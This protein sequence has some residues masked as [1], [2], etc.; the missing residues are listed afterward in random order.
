MFKR[1]DNRVSALCVLGLATVVHVGGC[2]DNDGGITTGSGGVTSSGGAT[3]TGG[4]GG[5][6]SGGGDSGGA[7]TS[8]GQTAD[9]GTGQ[10]GASAGDT[11]MGGVGEGGA[12]G[13]GGDPGGGGKRPARCVFHTE[14]LSEAP[15]PEGGAGGVAGAAGTTG[16]GSGTA[17]ADSTAGGAG[18]VG[19]G[20]PE[21]TIKSA[22]NSFAGLYLTDGAGK[23]LYTW[24]NDAPG[25]CEQ[26]PVSNCYTV[27]CLKSWPVFNGEPRLLGAGLDDALFGSITRTDGTLQTTYRGWPLYYFKDDLAEKDVKGHGVGVWN[28]AT[29][30]LPNIIELRIPNRERTLADGDGHVLYVSS[31]DTKGTSTSAPVSACAGACLEAFEPFAPS[32][33]SPV[34]YLP[35]TDF[36]YFVRPDGAPQLA[37][38]GAPLYL[39][40]ADEAP[41][42]FNGKDTAGFG[43]AVR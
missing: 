14:G 8:G 7:S 28:L 15:A 2:S 29:I 9:G 33:L 24:G 43:V 26:V 19:G 13:G 1:L 23:A 30:V 10:G 38:K 4:R 36:T 18:G 21:P 20:G 32:Y 39:A 17:G 31:S 42:Q 41:A 16:G 22:K 37:Y 27:D 35:A 11:G 5:T 6:N 12:A 40:Y 25:N 34:S 3:A